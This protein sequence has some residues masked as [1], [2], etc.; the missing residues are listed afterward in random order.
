MGSAR[1]VCRGWAERRRAGCWGVLA[2]PQRQ[3]AE[4]QRPALRLLPGERDSRSPATVT[5]CP[6]T[7]CW[8]TASRPRPP[9]RYDFGPLFAHTAP[10]V[11]AATLA[12]CHLEGCRSGGRQR[13]GAVRTLADSQPAARAGRAGRRC[14]GEATTAARQPR[15]TATTCGTPASTRRWRCSTRRESRTSDGTVGRRG[16]Q[17]GSTVP[18]QAAS[19]SATCRGRSPR[20][21][22]AG[23]VAVPLHPAH[24]APLLAEVAAAVPPE[25]R[26]DRERARGRARTSSHPPPP[27]GL[28]RALTASGQVDLVIGPRTARVR[29]RTG[30]RHVGYGRSATSVGNGRAGRPPLRRR[31]PRW[32]AGVG[33]V[34]SRT[35]RHVSVTPSAVLLC[36]AIGSRTVWA[37]SP[38]AA[39]PA[40]PPGVRAELE[41]C[42][43]RAT[44]MSDRPV[45]PGARPAGQVAIGLLIEVRRGTRVVFTRCAPVRVRLG[46]HVRSRQL[47]VPSHGAPAV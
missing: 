31:C 25:R 42:H 32:A 28:R 45:A 41:M 20:T 30:E 37:A 12:I 6:R 11:A 3:V 26:G 10:I 19:A 43:A 1:R 40:T 21:G 7:E 13:V 33:R 44:R 18:G 39:N 38:R 47:C 46:W 2:L 8:R 35:G 14:G 5:S 24:P 15:T 16:A 4:T 27:T 34:A 17:F 22:T 29:P 9:R 36:N 23:D